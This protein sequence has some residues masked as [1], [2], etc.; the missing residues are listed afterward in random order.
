VSLAQVGFTWFLDNVE[1]LVVRAAITLL[2]LAIV[3]LAMWAVYASFVEQQ[4][5]TLSRVAGPVA[6]AATALA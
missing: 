2:G 4:A 5:Q 1:P 6:T 3:L